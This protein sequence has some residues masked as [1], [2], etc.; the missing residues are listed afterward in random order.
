MDFSDG[1]LSEMSHE[2]KA[3]IVFKEIKD[4][5]IQYIV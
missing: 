4:I 5:P 2:Q 3:N 1:L